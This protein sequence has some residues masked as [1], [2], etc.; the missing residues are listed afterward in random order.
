MLTD[1]SVGKKKAVHSLI[2]PNYTNIIK[3]KDRKGKP[4]KY[5]LVFKKINRM[6]VLRG[7]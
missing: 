7:S 1:I 5:C 6:R 4:G 3:P 2:Y